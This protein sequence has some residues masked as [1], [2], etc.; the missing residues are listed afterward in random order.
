[1]NLK[2][3]RKLKILITFSTTTFPFIL[4]TTFLTNKVSGWLLK[5]FLTSNFCVKERK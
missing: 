3:F 1:M 5:H 4:S 2:N